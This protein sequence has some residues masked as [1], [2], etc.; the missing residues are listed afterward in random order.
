MGLLKNWVC[1]GYINQQIFKCNTPQKKICMWIVYIKKWFIDKYKENTEVY[2]TQ[3]NISQKKS[4]F[5][6][7]S[8]L[9]KV[10]HNKSLHST[11]DTYIPRPRHKGDNYVLEKKIHE[12]NNSQMYMEI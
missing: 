1:C 8:H 4:K 3:Q 10:F 11:L 2:R 6:N 7:M 9:Q 12:I 5:F